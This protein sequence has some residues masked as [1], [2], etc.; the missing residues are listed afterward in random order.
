MP[1]SGF[2]LLQ[3]NIRRCHLHS[4][5]RVQ[6]FRAK[7]LIPDRYFPRSQQ[8]RRHGVPCFSCIYISF[9]YPR[10]LVLRHKKELLLS[11]TD[12]TAHWHAI[13]LLRLSISI[14]PKRRPLFKLKKHKKLYIFYTIR[15]RSVRLRNPQNA[16]QIVSCLR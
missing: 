13:P 6:N 14:Q 5:R 9:L 8:V 12:I 1:I 15:Q 16:L 7:A 10:T 2:R 3:E 11:L 4:Q